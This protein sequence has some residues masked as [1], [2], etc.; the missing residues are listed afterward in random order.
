MNL[1]KRMLLVAPVAVVIAL[2]TGVSPVS[3]D[4]SSSLSAESQQQ[5]YSQE[6]RK[7]ALTATII[8]PASPANGNQVSILVEG[9]GLEPGSR[10][11]TTYKRDGVEESGSIGDPV[12]K[13]GK[14]SFTAMWY[15]GINF[16]DLVVTATTKKGET[17]SVSIPT[18]C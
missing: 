3:A 13:N 2:G 1:R 8:D 17:V 15:C 10:V 12:G 14:Y 9:E 16:T 5:G 11:I 4:S 18:F 7:P 6:Q